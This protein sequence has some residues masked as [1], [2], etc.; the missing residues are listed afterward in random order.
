M[1]WFSAVCP[2]VLLFQHALIILGS[3]F[4]DQHRDVI[5]D[6]V[7]SSTL[8]Y[9][10]LTNRNEMLVA[11][12]KHS[13]SCAGCS[14]LLPSVSL[15]PN[16]QIILGSSF[17]DQP[18]DVVVDVVVG[19]GT[20]ILKEL[21]NR[22]EMLVVSHEHCYACVGFS[23]VWPSVL[24]LPNAQIILGSS[25]CDQPPDVVVDVVV[26]SGTL[27]LKELTNRNEMLVVSHEHCY[28]CAGFSA[29]WPSVLLLRNARIVLGSSFCDQPPD[30]V[31]DV[32]VGSGTLILQELTNRNEMLVVSHEHC[33]ECAG[34][35]SVWS[36]VLLLPNAQIILG[37]SFCDQRPDVV[38][39][40]VVGSCTLILQELTNRNEMLVVSHE[41]CYECAGISSVWSSVLLLPNAQIILGSSFCDQ[42]PDVVVDV[43]VG[44][45]TLILQEL[46]NRNEMLV[47][48]HEHCYACAG[49]S[50]VWSSVL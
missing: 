5:A 30:A 19:S 37:S 15:L 27:I 33:Y 10:E 35:S 14:I 1:R 22:N 29:V 12:H 42:R 32:V 24:L 3:S 28:A 39:D 2:S 21:T 44:S 7:G 47:V 41:H 8:I 23:V 17:C 26:E 45:C 49:F 43:V 11:F 4:C 46:T 40:V 16:A 34:I 48:S 20:L 38:V 50:A 13:Y 6:V 18:P 9:Q 36:S 25:F 31:V